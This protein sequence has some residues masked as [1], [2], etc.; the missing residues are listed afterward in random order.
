MQ[1]GGSIGRRIG[2][3]ESRFWSY[4]LSLREN[5]F[6]PIEN[7]AAYKDGATPSCSRNYLR[8]LRHALRLCL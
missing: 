2:N 5:V 4:E 1:R 8:D 3:Y 6:E 7:D